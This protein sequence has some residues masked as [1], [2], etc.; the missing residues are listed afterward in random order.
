MPARN[1][2][3][4]LDDSGRFIAV[5]SH[6]PPRQTPAAE[7]RYEIARNPTGRGKALLANRVR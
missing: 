2:F 3:A 6:K 4:K 5:V 7:M 1:W